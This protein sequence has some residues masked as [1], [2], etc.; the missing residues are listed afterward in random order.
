MIMCNH[1]I[2]IYIILLIHYIYNI[3]NLFLKINVIILNN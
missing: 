2:N 1:I 3:I